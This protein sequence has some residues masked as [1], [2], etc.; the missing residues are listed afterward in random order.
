VVADPRRDDIKEARCSLILNEHMP[1]TG[2]LD[3]TWRLLLHSVDER[4]SDD[5]VGPGRA[6]S[7]TNSA[8]LSH[9]MASAKWLGHSVVSRAPPASHRHRPPSLPNCVATGIVDCSENH[10]Y[11]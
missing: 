7:S 5:R 9:T 6:S 2:F 1:T 11:L 8:K 10:F 4:G 3:A